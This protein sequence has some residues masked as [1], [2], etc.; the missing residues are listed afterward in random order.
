VASQ[1]L[2]NRPDW[3]VDHPTPPIDLSSNVNY[4]SILHEKIRSIIGSTEVNLFDYPNDFAVYKSLSDYYALPLSN[5]SVGLGSAEIIER[6]IRALSPDFMYIVTPTWGMVEPLCQIYNIPYKCISVDEISSHYDHSATL[7]IANP[8]GQTGAVQPVEHLFKKFKYVMLD[9]A[10]SDWSPSCS[11]L[12]SCPDNVF[13]SKSIS[14]SLCVAGLR[15]GFVYAN[16]N[17]TEKLQ[18]IRPMY[19]TNRFAEIVLPEI[20][21][22]TPLVLDRLLYSKHK[23]ESMFDCSPSRANFVRFK[24]P[25]KLT[26]HFGSKFIDNHHKMAMA[27]WN[28]LKNVLS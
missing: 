26:K 15:V 1:K 21:W 11:H 22:D 10:Y 14:K 28:T 6:T 25:N 8:N 27:D 7:Y 9:E 17:F 24:E 5:I 19:V 13:I 20:I 18:S 2:V 12:H 16:K 3:R 23:L 4:D